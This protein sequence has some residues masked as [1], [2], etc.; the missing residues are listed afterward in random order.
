MK[1]AYIVDK[2]K[3]CIYT[4]SWVTLYGII[5]K[6]KMVGVIKRIVEH[7]MD[8]YINMRPQRKLGGLSPSSYMCSA[9]GT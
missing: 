6:D 4:G 8:Y 5:Y 7:Y 1:M 2:I 9:L 3:I